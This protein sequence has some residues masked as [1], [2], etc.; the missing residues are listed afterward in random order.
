MNAGAP[1]AFRGL[2]SAIPHDDPVSTGAR[3]DVQALAA[4]TAQLGG[5]SLHAPIAVNNLIQALSGATHRRS[6]DPSNVDRKGLLVNEVTDL[7]V[8]FLGE[9]VSTSSNDRPPRL[10]DGLQRLEGASREE[11]TGAV[12]FRH[13]VTLIV[14][15]PS[16]LLLLGLCAAATATLRRRKR[17][18]EIR[19]K[20][21]ERS[22]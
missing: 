14:P 16:T 1:N 4:I 21:I 22:A 13:R 8:D 10:P 7:A 6:D 9:S 12:V 5:P 19:R 15:E 11:G 20:V 17:A 3:L 18:D 2:E